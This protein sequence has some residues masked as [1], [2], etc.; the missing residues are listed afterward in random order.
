LIGKYIRPLSIISSR[1]KFFNLYNVLSYHVYNIYITY[2]HNQPEI[3]IVNAYLLYNIM[4]LYSFIYLFMLI[5]PYAQNSNRIILETTSECISTKHTLVNIWSISFTACFTK[6]CP[7]SNFCYT[8]SS[9]S[10]DW[11]F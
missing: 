8:F 7:P 1:S 5:W 6:I 10:P 4:A 11:N 9:N 2:S 3:C